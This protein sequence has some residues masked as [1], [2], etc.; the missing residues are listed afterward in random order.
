[1]IV[2]WD[3][4]E[5]TVRLE[6][7]DGEHRQAYEWQANRELADKM[8]AYLRDRLAEHNAS[9]IG[10]T[11]I[12]VLRGPGSFTGLRIG[13]TVLNTLATAL[14]VPIVGEIGDDWQQKCLERLA[15]GQNDRIVLPEYGGEAHTTKPRK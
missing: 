1:M 11:G 7:I 5:M 8:H 2:L 4:S 6:L 15:N 14:N 12:G 13:L 10:I 9:F 3:S